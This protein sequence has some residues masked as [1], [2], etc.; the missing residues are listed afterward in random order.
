MNNVSY[1]TVEGLHQ[2]PSFSQVAVVSASAEW[3]LIGGQNAVAEDGSIDGVGDVAVQAARVRT[4]IELALLSREC[5]WKDA[6]RFQVFLKEGVDARNA[7][8]PFADVLQGRPSP[9]LVTMCWVS[10]LAHPDFLLEVSCDA[11]KP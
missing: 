11:V 9:P 2:S 7:F 5:T 8:T 1:P 6:V 4:N 3:V 10:A